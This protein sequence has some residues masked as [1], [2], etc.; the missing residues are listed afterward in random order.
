MKTRCLIFLLIA[1]SLGLEARAA[2]SSARGS[3]SAVILAPIHVKNV[4]P[5]DFGILL[6]SSHSGE[7]K[8]TPFAYREVTGDVDLLP[9]VYAPAQFALTGVPNM[10]YSITAPN[11]VAFLP[12]SGTPAGPPGSPIP[13]EARD[14]TTYSVTLHS[15]ELNGRL[16]PY[17]H[18]L[19]SLGGT[20]VVTAKASPG[21]YLGFV[22]I[23]VAY[24]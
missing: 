23:A 21:H 8:I 5:L 14:F 19:V 7:V 4:S 13:L 22:P 24:Q 10:Y 6:P 20:L 15:T 16:N 17:G 2:S 9:A 18:D 3:A 1:L 12:E 11:T